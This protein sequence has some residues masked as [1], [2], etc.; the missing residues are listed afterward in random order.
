MKLPLIAAPKWADKV[1]LLYLIYAHGLSWGE[2]TLTEAINY[3]TPERDKG[4]SFTHIA[5]RWDDHQMITMLK[6]KQ[7]DLNAYQIMNSP[8]QFIRCAKR[9]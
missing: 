2:D 7:A 8:A 6:E 5:V 1:R 3:Y 4:Y 9:L